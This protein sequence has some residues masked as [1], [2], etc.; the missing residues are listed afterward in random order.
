MGG[1]L[2]NR[3]QADRSEEKEEVNNYHR[4][5]LLNS[6]TFARLQLDRAVIYNIKSIMGYLNNI[7]LCTRLVAYASTKHCGD[8]AWPHLQAQQ[9]IPRTERHNN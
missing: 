5:A 1:S 6:L 8:E 4:H 7:I 3:A 9:D 2:C